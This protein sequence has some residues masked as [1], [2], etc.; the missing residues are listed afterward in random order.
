[1]TY[2]EKHIFA[3]KQERELEKSLKKLR[4]RTLYDHFDQY[5]KKA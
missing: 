5:S 1:M 4:N 2:S 3:I